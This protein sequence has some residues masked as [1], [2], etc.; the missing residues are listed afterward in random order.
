MEYKEKIDKIIKDI[1]ETIVDFTSERVKSRKPTSAHSEF[2]TNRAQGDWAEMIVLKTINRDLHDYVAVSYGMSDDILAGEEGF[3]EFYDEYQKELCEIGKRP[4]LLIF[5]KKDYDISWGYNISKFSREVLAEIVPKAVAG[6]EVRSSSFIEQEYLNEAQK[7]IEE[8]K[9]QAMTLL[10]KI[11]TFDA[12][13]MNEKTR[14][15]LEQITEENLHLQ[16]FTIRLQNDHC[17]YEQARETVK[18][19]KDAIK[20]T[21]KRDFLSITPKMEDMKLIHKWIRTYG[22]PHYFVQVFYDKVYGIGFE[23]ILTLI[24]DTDNQNKLFFI[25][26]DSRNQMKTTIKINAKQGKE[27]A[28]SKVLPL[29][30]S[31]RKVFNRG[32]VVHYVALEHGKMSLQ[33]QD[34]LHL[35]QEK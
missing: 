16:H 19:F 15:L 28:V 14:N 1:P 9:Q 30:R 22:V 31:R 18:T 4:D 7:R 10:D 2:L 20:Q 21:K 23:E 27:I 6:L 29:H 35:I 25:E 3:D 8:N 32:R 26:Q 5:K 33:T 24:S 12:A 11:L 13:L 34:F 17:N